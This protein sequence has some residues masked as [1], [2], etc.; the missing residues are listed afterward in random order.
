M[1]DKQYWERDGKE[2]KDKIPYQHVDQHI[3]NL[4]KIFNKLPFLA[5]RSSCEGH[6]KQKSKIYWSASGGLLIETYNQKAWN[7]FIL[8]LLLKFQELEFSLSLDKRYNATEDGFM[9][10]WE[11]EWSVSANTEEVCKICLKEIWI[12]LEKYVSDYLESS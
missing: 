9:N 10:D 4:V 1:K 12:I 6:L 5:T 11:L 2:D 8:P 3:V 7:E